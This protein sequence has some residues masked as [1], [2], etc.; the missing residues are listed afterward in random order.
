MPSPNTTTTLP[1]ERALSR[2]N[3]YHTSFE[4]MFDRQ[5]IPTPTLRSNI[6]SLNCFVDQSHNG[7]FGRKRKVLVVSS[8]P[9]SGNSTLLTSFVK[10]RRTRSVPGEYVLT[11]WSESSEEAQQLSAVITR[12]IGLLGAALGNDLTEWSGATRCD[13][14][15]MVSGKPSEQFLM[16]KFNRFVTLALETQMTNLNQN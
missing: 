5:T 4:E 11:H 16:G 10:Q 9:G 12:W 3:Q 14:E 6:Q 8:P 13:L 2:S 1:F 7:A 15:N